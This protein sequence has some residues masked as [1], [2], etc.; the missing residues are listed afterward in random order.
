MIGFLYALPAVLLLIAIGMLFIDIKKP[1][2]IWFG[3]GAGVFALILLMLTMLLVYL[4]QADQKLLL[5]AMEQQ[6]QAQENKTKQQSLLLTQ[7]A[8]IKLQPGEK[9]DRYTQFGLAVNNPFFLELD[10]INKTI[11]ELTAKPG[12]RSPKKVSVYRLPADS[13]QLVLAEYL[14][15]LGYEAYIPDA[16]STEDEDAE[17][18]DD[19]EAAEDKTE[20]A[21]EPPAPAEKTASTES[22]EAAPS[23]ATG[24][25]TEESGEDPEVN[26]DQIVATSTTDLNKIKSLLNFKKGTVSVS[27]EP[28]DGHDHG[29]AHATPKTSGPAPINHPVLASANLLYYG[30]GVSDY[31]IKVIALALMRSGVA[32]KGIRT[33][34]ETNRP[35][36]TELDWSAF[37]EKR[38]MIAPEK[39]ATKKSFDR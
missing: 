16:N 35:Y 32:L 11:K 12:S 8:A 38:P 34:K 27:T 30:T 22:D 21:V 36:D 29:D 9:Y 20:K 24:T 23:E 1:K 25:T 26:G 37:Y 17:N 31:D 10:K 3:V 7:L 18:A 2:H 4:S 13:N 6:E 5:K 39:I 14:R 33:F 15:S 19:A 28:V